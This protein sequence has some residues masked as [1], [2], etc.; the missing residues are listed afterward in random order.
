M[1]SFTQGLALLGLNSTQQRAATAQ[2]NISMAL[3]RAYATALYGTHSE[4]VM[5]GLQQA[6]LLYTDL[7]P[8]LAALN[9]AVHSVNYPQVD[10]EENKNCSLVQ[11][12]W[13]YNRRSL[14]PFD[15]DD[16]VYVLREAE[17]EPIANDTWVEVSRCYTPT[18]SCEAPGLHYF[19]RATGSGVFFNV[20]KTIVERRHNICKPG[21]G[22]IAFK[23]HLYQLQRQG[24]DSIQFSYQDDEVCGGLTSEIVALQWPM[25][26]IDRTWAQPDKDESTICAAA[27]E[28][29]R[30]GWNASL[31]CRCRLRSSQ[32]RTEW[33][34]DDSP[35]SRRYGC[36]RCDPYDL[37]GLKAQSVLPMEYPSPP[38]PPP[39]SPKPP[40]PPPLP[41]PA[42]P[43]R[44]PLH[45]RQRDSV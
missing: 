34:M 11:E 26:Q 28:K 9:L 18:S 43:P 37:H 8:P 29:L 41:H 2:V 39:P 45:H 38:P 22:A 16:L 25:R 35:L 1:G 27:A 6:A 7:L 33:I 13:L 44:H 23:G 40:P 32:R 19:Y 17:H 15:P 36:V 3:L 42:R 24:Y 10:I 4:S 12:G 21:H 20:G 5:L 31:P 14:A 30:G